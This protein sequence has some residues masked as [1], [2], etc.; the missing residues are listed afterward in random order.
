M[1]P[2]EFIYTRMI[3][4][5]PNFRAHEQSE[6]ASDANEWQSSLQGQGSWIWSGSHEKLSYMLG[7]GKDAVGWQ[8][9]IYARVVTVGS[10][11]G[12]ILDFQAAGAKFGQEG[13]RPLV[14]SRWDE[15]G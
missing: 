14:L 2:C 13:R 4:Q 9:V 6:A 11:F 3:V 8:R 12:N 7:T 5:E 15:A 10:V 1:G